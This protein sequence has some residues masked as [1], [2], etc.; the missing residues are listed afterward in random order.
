MRLADTGFVGPRDSRARRR[1]RR[2]DVTSADDRQAAHDSVAATHGSLDILINNAGIW[3]DSPDAATPPDRPPDEVATA[4][5]FLAG[6]DA[7]Y[8]TGSVLDVNG[9]YTA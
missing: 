7:G 2:L 8:I 3:L 9:G 4:I 5:V 6:P 1:T